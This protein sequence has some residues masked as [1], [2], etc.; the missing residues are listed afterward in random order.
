LSIYGDPL[1]APGT[2][3]TPVR[4]GTMYIPQAARS[5]LYNPIPRSVAETDPVPVAGLNQKDRFFMKRETAGKDEYR[6]DMRGTCG[7]SWDAGGMHHTGVV[8]VAAWSRWRR[9]I[10]VVRQFS[11]E[12]TSRS[13]PP[14]GICCGDVCSSLLDVARAWFGTG[15]GSFFSKW[16]LFMFITSRVV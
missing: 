16:L 12:L 4:S 5:F 9:T 13:Q 11:R 3:S 14:A 2:R 6:Q 10:V 15:R 7:P 8:V 1:Q